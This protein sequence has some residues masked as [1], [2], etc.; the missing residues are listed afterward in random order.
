MR[1]DCITPSPRRV[2]VVLV[3]GLALAA[4]ALFLDPP[5]A[6]FAQRLQPGGDIHLGGDVRR[7]IEWLQ[8]FG[9]AATCLICAICIWLLDPAR[10]RDLPRAL[11]ALLGTWGVVQAIKMLAGRPRP[12]VVFGHPQPGFDAIVQFTPPWRAYP[13]PHTDHGVTTYVLQHAWTLGHG[14]DLWSFPSSHTSAAAALAVVLSRL[15]PRLTPLV[16]FLVACVGVGR[17]VLGAHFPS[18]VIAGAAVGY[19]AATLLF[20]PSPLAPQAP[21][22]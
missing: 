14:S 3:S 21:N 9:D 13:L 22:T 16:W 7:T 17:V 6:T 12:R 2:A 1:S 8:Q 4:L 19:A 5:I 18:D 20:R 11:L 15:Y 10:R